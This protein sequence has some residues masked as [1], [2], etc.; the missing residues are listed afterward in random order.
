MPYLT[1]ILSDCNPIELVSLCCVLS[2][3]EKTIKKTKRLFLID[4]ETG[5]CKIDEEVINT[6][7]KMLLLDAMLSELKKTGHKVC[8]S[9]FG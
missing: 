2:I 8:L 7:G 9:A 6:S 1:I 3:Y 4:P 5:Y